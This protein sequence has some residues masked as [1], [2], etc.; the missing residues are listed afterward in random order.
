M[1]ISLTTWAIILGVI[2]L[3]GLVKGTTGFGF[4]LFSLPLLVHFVPIKTLIPLL[5]LFNLTSSI[6]IALL[7]GKFKSKKSIILLSIFGIAGVIS[8]SFLLKFLP[9]LWLKI[10]ISFVLIVLSFMFLTGYRFKIRRIKRGNSIAGFISGFL[11]GSLAVSGPPLALFLTSL[12]IDSQNFRLTFAWF[13]VITASVA[14]FDYIKMGIFQFSSL[15]IFVVSIP[16]LIASIQTGKLIS[17]TVSIKIFYFTVVSVTLLSGIF[18][19]L[20]SL[21]EF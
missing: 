16:V 14:F 18:L 19:L 12:K 15:K 13:S 9:E 11:G 8:G 21:R 2:F 1:N 6:Q 17:K 5:T 3:S 10:L 7:S 4:A 20:S